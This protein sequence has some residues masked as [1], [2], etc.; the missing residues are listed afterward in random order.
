MLPRQRSFGVLGSPARVDH[1]V[2]A[3]G[4]GRLVVPHHRKDAAI[5]DHHIGRLGVRD[6]A[7]VRPFEVDAIAGAG[8]ADLP[9][10]PGGIPPR[11]RYAERFIALGMAACAGLF[12]AQA[13]DEKPFGA[14]PQTVPDV[15]RAVGL[16][17]AGER[18]VLGEFVQVLFQPCRRAVIANEP[19]AARKQP[20]ARFVGV[21]Q[22]HE[23]QS[24]GARV[25]R[26]SQNWIDGVHTLCLPSGPF[27]TVVRERR[28]WGVDADFHPAAT[29][30]PDSPRLHHC[31][32]ATISSV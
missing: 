25:I 4:I 27:P 19:A 21:F 16:L 8:I 18:Q 2:A 5:V 29:N 11:P 30:L 28:L 14:A 15:D 32:A 1:G 23:E 20:A 6:D 26:L 24:Q 22:G 7:Q 31:K 3:I 13:V 10:H 12:G 9:L 17:E